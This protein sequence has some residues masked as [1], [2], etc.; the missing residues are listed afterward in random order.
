MSRKAVLTVEDLTRT[1]HSGK[2]IRDCAKELGTD[3]DRLKC[4][5]LALFG[6]DAYARRKFAN[7]S[8]ATSGKNN[9]QTRDKAAGKTHRTAKRPE[10]KARVLNK[11]LG[12]ISV[13]APDWFTGVK[14][15]GGRVH[16]HVLVYCQHHSLTEIPAGYV[17]HH[18]N[19]DKTDNRIENL[20]LMTRSEHARLHLHS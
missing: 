10:E 1:F 20:E 14:D 15:N 5:W 8:A 19:E 13:G 16:E 11:H 2:R 9:Y 3:V 12:Y 4:E 18:K 7:H 17:I 6:A